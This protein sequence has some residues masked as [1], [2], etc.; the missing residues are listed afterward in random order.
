MEQMNA[1]IEQIRKERVVLFLGSGFSLKAGAPS[2]SAICESLKSKLTKDEQDSLNGNQLDYVSNEFEQ[3]RDRDTLIQT[4]KKAFTFAP[5]DL[6]NQVALTQIPH[7]ETII[8]TN[9]DTLLE[10]T[11]GDNCVVVRSAQDCINLPSNKVRIYKIHGDFSATENLIITKNDYRKYFAENSDNSLWKLV[12]SFLLTKD[13][14]FIGYSLE[15]DNVFT[16]L[17]NIQ[18]DTNQHKENVFLVSPSVIKSKQN[19]LASL[20]VKYVDSRAEDFFPMLIQSLNK[21]IIKDLQRKWVSAETASRYCTLHNIQLTTKVL[22]T[23]NKVEKFELTGDKNL[24]QMHLS[25]RLDIV[26]AITRRDYSLFTDTLPSVLN[27]KGIPVKQIS[28]EN[29]SNFNFEVNGI[30]LYDKNDISAIYVLPRYSTISTNI[31]IPAIGFNSDVTIQ[32]YQDGQIVRCTLQTE[33]YD[34]NATL[35]AKDDNSAFALHFNISFTEKYTNN[36]EALKWIGFLIAIFDGKE[37]HI[38]KLNQ[39]FHGNICEEDVNFFNGYKQYYQNISEI[40]S[41]SNSMFDEYNNYTEQNLTH[42]KYVLC[43]LKH[44]PLIKPTPNGTDFTCSAI[45]HSQSELPPVQGNYCILLPQKNNQEFVV[46]GRV[47]K[48]PYQNAFMRNCTLLSIENKDNN[49]ALLHFH[50]DE[51]ETLFY[52]TDQPARLEGNTIHLS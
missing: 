38:D 36:S 23:E 21:N 9:Y 47:Y 35:S 14:L 27:I 5:K 49:T 16:M 7:F 37:I 6:C 20:N 50:D 17:E 3:M 31:K 19:K 40:E 29:M 28:S 13:V 39:T 4:L 1:L 2:A 18:K 48:I 51:T 22:P 34:I 26:D 32:A 12:Q 52:L 46:N 25:T 15:D 10:D 42:S 43:Y 45:N 30:S 44:L 24:L 11:Y 41:L 8:T 33:I